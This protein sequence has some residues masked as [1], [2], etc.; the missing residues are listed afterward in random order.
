[1]IDHSQDYNPRWVFD[2]MLFT[3]RATANTIA[4]R[5]AAFWHWDM[6]MALPAGQAVPSYAPI[7]KTRPIC[8]WRCFP[9][10]R[11]RK[12]ETATPSAAWLR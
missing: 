2:R 1:V 5:S 4:K 3:S 12:Q 11:R 6:N 7:Y 9:A 8:V 10:A